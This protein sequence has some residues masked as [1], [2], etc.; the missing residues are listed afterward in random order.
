[1][2]DKLAP[3]IVGVVKVLF[4][5]VCVEARST[6]V[7]VPEG[8]VAVVAAVVVRFRENAPD[9]VRVEPDTPIFVILL[10]ALS[11]PK[12]AI[13]R[14][15]AIF[16]FPSIVYSKWFRNNPNIYFYDTLI[17]CLTTRTTVFVK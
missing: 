11:N 3:L 6:S 4:V 13:K 9:C 14:L 5:S 17:V 10:P 7:I 15:L 2:P 12:R 16:I 1:M 8:N